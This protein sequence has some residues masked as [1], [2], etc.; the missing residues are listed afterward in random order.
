MSKFATLNN[1]NMRLRR[2]F[3]RRQRLRVGDVIIDYDGITC[4]EYE[5]YRIDP[6]LGIA[7]GRGVWEGKDYEKIFGLE[8]IDPRHIFDYPFDPSNPDPPRRFLV[9]R[10]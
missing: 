6:V 4:L 2:L 3:K 5:I 8:F 10:R 1:K 9:N 7:F